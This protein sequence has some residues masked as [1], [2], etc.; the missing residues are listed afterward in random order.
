M[1]DSLFQGDR[2]RPSHYA[3]NQEEAMQ[4]ILQPPVGPL[5]RCL[6]ANCADCLLPP[7]LA[8]SHYQL[9]HPV[10][11]YPQLGQGLQGLQDF[12]PNSRTGLDIKI[13]MHTSLENET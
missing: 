12:F 10:H 9:Q 2:M 13:A 1:A 4:Q 6:Q 7:P 5:S 8:G 11:G 3:E